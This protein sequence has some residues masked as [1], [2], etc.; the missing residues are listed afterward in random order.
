MY[1][2]ICIYIYIYIYV[3]AGSTVDPMGFEPR[4]L[5][6]YTYIRCILDQQ[7]THWDLNP[8]P[9]ACKADVIPLHHEPNDERSAA[10]A[11]IS[12]SQYK[13]PAFVCLLPSPFSLLPPALHVF[14]CSVCENVCVSRSPFGDHPIQFRGTSIFSWPLRNDDTHKSRC[15][16]FLGCSVQVCRYAGK[17][18]L[19]LCNTMDTTTTAPAG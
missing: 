5:N 14:L 3:Y 12:S 19:S 9:S 15:V 1:V 17:A 6:K 10:T 13:T 2:Y 7:W 18:R 16:H 11:V 8:G 4:V